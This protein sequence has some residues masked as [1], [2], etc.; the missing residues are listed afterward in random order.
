MQER[1]R[2]TLLDGAVSIA[3]IRR[4]AAFVHVMLPADIENNWDARMEAARRIA[5]AAYKEHHGT[6]YR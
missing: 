4:L 1:M 2:I 5:F 3:N 6:A